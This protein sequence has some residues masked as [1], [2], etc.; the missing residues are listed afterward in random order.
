MVPN[1][2]AKTPLIQRIFDSFGSDHTVTPTPH[3]HGQDEV[4]GLGTALSN[5]NTALSNL[6]TALSGKANANHSH[7][8]ITNG[9]GSVVGFS[10]NGDVRLNPAIGKDVIIA[11]GSNLTIIS[12]SNVANLK[13]ALLDPSSTPEND[14]T[15]LITS[16]AVYDALLGKADRV[17]VLTVKVERVNGHAA[18]AFNAASFAAAIDFSEE[19]YGEPQSINLFASVYHDEEKVLEFNIPTSVCVEET[20]QLRFTLHL[21]YNGGD[22]VVSGSVDDIHGTNP[23]FNADYFVFNALLED[24]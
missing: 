11:F 3:T 14:A 17:P 23:Q 8:E 5:F 9:N 22:Y 12:S 16:K 20:D 1:N 6:N 18:F 10:V 4:S 15:K 13:R 21:Y 19:L 2:S 7:N 24:I